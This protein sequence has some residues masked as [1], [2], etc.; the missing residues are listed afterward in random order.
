MAT[1]QGKRTA[2]DA[3]LENYWAR[4]T[5]RQAFDMPSLESMHIPPAFIELPLKQEKMAKKH[6]RFDIPSPRKEQPAP[7]P[8][9]EPAPEP[10]QPAQRPSEAWEYDPARG[11]PLSGKFGAVLNQPMRVIVTTDFYVDYFVQEVRKIM[12][13]AGW[14][15]AFCRTVLTL[16]EGGTKHQDTQVYI[17]DQKS[18]CIECS[19][20]M[21]KKG[22]AY[23]SRV[24]RH[25]F[26]Y[27]MSFCRFC[28]P[29]YAWI[30]CAYSLLW[31]AGEPPRNMPRQGF[32]PFR[33][34]MFFDGHDAEMHGEMA[35]IEVFEDAEK[36][37]FYGPVISDPPRGD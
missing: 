23:V 8:A 15:A 21:K 34:P 26:D 16:M 3:R 17:S 19:A 10:A 22:T 13:E 27:G 20:C 9:P 6:V 36:I 14:R 35:I 18:G 2:A 5:V 37:K 4:Q 24:K 28:F 29:F 30:A 33:T 31:S 12:Q 25:Y 1:A 7:A 11:R 32:Y